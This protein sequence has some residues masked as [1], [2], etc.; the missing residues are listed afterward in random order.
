MTIHAF[1]MV[2]QLRDGNVLPSLAFMSS[3]IAMTRARLSA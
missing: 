2:F 1:G 3:R